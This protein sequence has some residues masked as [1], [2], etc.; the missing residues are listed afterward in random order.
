MP[1]RNEIV[2]ADKGYSKGIGTAATRKIDYSHDLMTTEA[3]Q[4]IERHREQPFFLYLAYTIPHAN[5][6]A[7]LI[8]SHGMEVPDLGAYADEDWPEV[9]K[10]QAAMIS[11]LDADVGRLLELLAKLGIAENTLVMFSSDN[12]PHQEGGMNYDAEFNDSNGPLRG[13]K[14]D[15]Y[16]GGIR[17]PMIAWWPGT[18]AAGRVTDHISAFWDV[19]PTC[20][21]LAGVNPPAG[22]DGISF[23]PTLLNRGRQ[24]QH[25]YLYWE[26][27]WWK[28]SRQAIRMG[29]WKAVKNTPGARIELYDLAT[30]IGEQHDVAKQFPDVIRDISPLFGAAR[31]DNPDFP[32]KYE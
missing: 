20:A 4:F 30:D 25:K 27:H 8:H 21:E 22:I 17:V 26:F 5:N 11:R 2:V 6:E 28:P 19:L 9:Q 18:I 16:E 12:G 7:H 10:A 13:I 24:K 14:R 1:L 3:L 32:M 23:V 31:N 15:L 29:R